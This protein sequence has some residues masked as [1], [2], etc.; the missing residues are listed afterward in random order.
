MQKRVQRARTMTVA[1]NSAHAIMSD[2]QFEAI[3]N[4][5]GTAEPLRTTASMVLVDGWRIVDAAL[6]LNTK[7]M[8]VGRVVRRMQEAHILLARAY[9]GTEPDAQ[10][11]PDW[12]ESDGGA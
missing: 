6:A 8:V 2:R 5:L 3:A 11:A 1:R 4:L 10:L 12:A 7:R 9:L